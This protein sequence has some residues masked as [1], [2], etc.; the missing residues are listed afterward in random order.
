MCCG[1]NRASM[2]R[3]SP[4]VHAV[5][6]VQQPKPAAPPIQAGPAFYFEYRGQSALIVVG[7]VTRARY[8]FSES[9][10]RLK[11]DSRDHAALRLIP[12][13]IEVRSP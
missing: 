1:K 10:K 9:G 11:V 7:S 8:Y 6:S 3:A 13:L 2:L 12:Q 4:V 5:R